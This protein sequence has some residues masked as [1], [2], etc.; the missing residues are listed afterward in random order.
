MEREDP[1]YRLYVGIDIA[2]DTFTAAWLAGG[3]TPSTPF[4]AEQTPSGFAALQRR[5]RGVAAPEGIL[6]VLE[7]TANYWVA[8][9]VALHEAGVRVA[10]VNPRPAHHCAKAQLRR[11]KTAALDARALAQLAAALRPSP[12]TPPPAV[13]HEVR[14]RLVAR[15]ALLVMRTLVRNQRHALLQWPVV[16]E[17]VCQHLDE[18]I[19]DLDRRIAR[20]DIEHEHAFSR[21]AIWQCPQALGP[22]DGHEQQQAAPAPPAHLHE[23]VFAG[24]HRA[25]IHAL[26]GD[27]RSPAP[28]DR[29][30]DPQHQRPGGGEGRRQHAQQH[31]PRGQAG[32]PGAV[33]H[34]VI[35]PEV[36]APAQ[37]HR[38]QSADEQ[39]L[40][41]LTCYCA[42][43]Q[44]R[45]YLSRKLNVQLGHT[46]R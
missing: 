14:Q 25:P 35:A 2:A 41:L 15:D 8:L 3:G 22:R 4:S 42:K 44:S 37:A 38:A 7:A 9:A 17:G 45:A 27:P 32:P 26:G 13:Y 29:L 20:L 30:V 46:A 43:G 10:V 24:A 11:A 39:T 12:W 16:V 33:E 1:G 19:T 18:L 23:I 5:L 31:P 34:P 6:V 21:C 40:P 36:L 28:L